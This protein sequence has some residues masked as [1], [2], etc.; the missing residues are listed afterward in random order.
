[1]EG[2]TYVLRMNG[3]YMPVY[4]DRKNTVL[5]LYVQIP[6]LTV[7]DLI[8]RSQSVIPAVAVLGENQAYHSERR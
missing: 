6:H 3:V 7:Y 5:A 1:M 8:R 4:I 2:S